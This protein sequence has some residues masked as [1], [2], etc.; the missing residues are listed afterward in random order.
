MKKF[1]YPVLALGAIA[2]LA[3]CASDEPINVKE[4]DGTARFSIRLPNELATR[5]NDGKSAKQLYY[6]VFQDGKYVLDGVITD[7]FSNNLTQEVGIQLVANQEYQIVFFADNATSE[8]NG[9]TYDPQSAQFDVT[10]S[11]KMVNSDDFDAFVN[12]I[13]YT[14]TGEGT[15]VPL[16]RPFAQLN[17]GTNDLTNGAVTHIG[18]DKFSSTLTI[19][20]TNILSGINFLSG[21][22]TAYS[23]EALSFSIPSFASL[24][25]DAFPVDNYKYIEMN[26]LLVP[27]TGEGQN[28][29]ID[30]TY[31]IEANS[32]TGNTLNLASTPVKTNYQTNVYG[33]LLTT[34]NKF[35]VEIKPAFE[36][37]DFNAGTWDGTTV[38]T[39]TVD[40]TAKTVGINQPS[41]LLGFI[42][43]VNGA[44]DTAPNDFEGYTIKVNGDYDF[45]GNEIP[46]IAQGATRNGASTQGT[47]FKGVFDGQGH[48]LKNFTVT[49]T[50]DNVDIAT[51]FIAN[52]TGEG[53]ALQNVNFENIRIS[54]V[55]G[56]QAGVVGLVTDGAKISNVKVLSG[57]VSAK[58]A[59][60]GIAGR[61]MISG[62]IEN[63]SNAAA[64]SSKTQNAG[65]IVGASY[66]TAVGKQTVVRGCSNSG[67]VHSNTVAAGGI[68]GL[69]TGLVEKCNNTGAVSADQNSAGGIVGVQQAAG[70]VRNCENSGNITCNGTLGVGG[71][72]GWVK[73]INGSG[74]QAQNVIEVTGCVN[75][76]TITGKGAGTY[77]VSGIVGLWYQAG[78]CSGNTN[79]APLIDAAGMCAGITVSQFT[80]TN[81]DKVSDYVEMLTISD[82]TSTT[83]LSQLTGSLKA[84]IAYLN[85]ASKVTMTGN[86]PA[87]NQ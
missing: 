72:V 50:G 73:Y 79:N 85:D 39:P 12:T 33:S 4:Y 77:G 6:S 84:L 48:T 7:A 47:A 27:A 40:A 2:T 54:T 44:G 61:M 9:Y 45:A 26:Y 43:M 78:I 70:Y 36:T 74:Y 19:Q 1:L 82:N 22:E 52:L 41:D 21:N 30:A 34:Q 71:I 67:T 64:I 3:S 25:A 24:P 86:T 56:E 58:E 28:S 15:D 59:P 62:T 49:E 46:M 42:Q 83:T 29:L 32:T 63:C 13:T 81:P 66:R 35:N 87:N 11:N 31:V 65:G 55:N 10:Y 76:G 51:G 8:S 68:S 37:P 14:A 57:S 17:I 60:G 18:L 75:S 80:G 16:K 23:G 53:A 5:F 38:T 69:N 20:P